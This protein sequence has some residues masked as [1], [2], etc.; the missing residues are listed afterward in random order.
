MLSHREDIL[1]L[2]EKPVRRIY[3][4]DID[5]LN[6]QI[7]N[8]EE[9]IGK[10]KYDLE[11][12][13]EYAVAYFES[14]VKKY[15]KGRNRKTEIKLFDTITAN[16]VAIANSKLYINRAEGFIGTGL[17]KDE[18]LCDCSNLDDV[19][20]FTKRGMMKVVRVADKT[21]IG[22]D[23]L[24]AAVFQKNDERTTYNLDLCRW[25]N[26]HW[27][28]KRFNVTGITRDK[29]YD[30]TK[31]NDKS[32]VLY[33]SANPNG[34]AETVKVLLS[35][36][37][38]ARNKELDFSFEE[39]DIKG[40]SSIG[41]QVTKHAIRSVKFKEKGRPTLAG[42]KLW[43]D[44]VYNRLN[45]DGKGRFVGSF[46]GDE[47]ILVI[48]AGGYYELTDTETPQRFENDKII[49]IEKFDPEKIISAVYLDNEKKQY[50]VKRFKIETTT[51]HSHFYCVKEG[52]G[53]CMENATTQKAPVL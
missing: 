46:E 26:G 16:Q 38:N 14:L 47:K 23:I 42:R 31:G 32:K 43:Y 41:N 52:V 30:L 53:N 21:F 44:D 49:V 40:R 28:R 33:F 10:V 25:R 29:E 45:A 35:P 17:K 39:I 13:T 18:F 22:K 7:K 37:S 24:H 20:V 19:I 5:E 36:N 12:L 6:A 9:E 4:L 51:M 48:Y 50:N 3:K 1:K 27:F 8:I 15:G 2:T 34:E 11:H